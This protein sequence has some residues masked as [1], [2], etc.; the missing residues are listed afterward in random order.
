MTEPLVITVL[1]ENSVS[2]RGLLAE[3]GLALHLQAGKRAL[4][5]DMDK[6]LAAFRRLDIQ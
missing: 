1:V 3:H 2:R 4:L 6:T 5:F